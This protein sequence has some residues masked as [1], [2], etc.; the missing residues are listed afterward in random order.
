MLPKMCNIVLHYGN[1]L[2]G[3]FA[4]EV[5]I[6]WLRQG[7]NYCCELILG[8][9]TTKFIYF[10]N[11]SDLLTMATIIT[12][13]DRYLFS[14]YMLKHCQLHLARVTKKVLGGRY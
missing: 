7:M 6:T 12:H 14:H 2:C 4:F 5:L 9:L 3:T 8:E 10:L 1:M 11:C 13:F